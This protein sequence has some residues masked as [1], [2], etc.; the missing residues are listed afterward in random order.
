[1]T[2]IKLW[3][4]EK[5]GRKVRLFRFG[6]SIVPKMAASYGICSIAE[7]GTNLFL[8]ASPRLFHNAVVQ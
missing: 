3:N 6:R 5:A 7:P 8:I 2:T 4:E 1:M